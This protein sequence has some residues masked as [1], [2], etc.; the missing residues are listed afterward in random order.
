M[1]TRCPRLDAVISRRTLLTAGAT[2]M[3]FAAGSVA[4]TRRARADWEVLALIAAE[5]G[6]KLRTG[7]GER[8]KSIV[9][10]PSGSTVRI[11][12]GPNDDGWYRVE[13]VEAATPQPGWIEGVALAFVTRVQAVEGLSMLGLP[14]DW[15]TEFAWVRRGFVVTLI[16]VDL[17]DWILVRSGDRVGYVS[18]WSLAKTEQDETD[19]AGEYWV[20]VNRSSATVGLCVGDTVVDR[21]DASLSADD[22][23]GFYATADGT[24]RIYQK[25]EGL[26]YTPYADAYFADWAGFDPDRF[27]GFHSWIMDASGNVL[28]GGSDATF[29]CVAT[30]PAHAAVIYDFV[31]LGTRVEIHW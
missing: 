14:D 11:L 1:P 25:L 18:A 13:D 30:S 5:D 23:D 6:A 10:L 22:G 7:P 31:D 24:Y 8:R 4:Q 12:D 28:D 15:A 27:N 20:D 2:A 21:F 19:P 29:G 3:A 9:V 17:G 16:G 26:T